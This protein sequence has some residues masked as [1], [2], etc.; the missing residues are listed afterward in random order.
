MR[1]LTK[2]IIENAVADYNIKQIY[3]KIANDE[4]IFPHIVF[5][6]DAY[7]QSSDDLNRFNYVVYID[8]YDKKTSKYSIEEIADRI[9]DDEQDSHIRTQGSRCLFKNISQIGRVSNS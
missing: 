9:V 5:D 2:S 1:K 3:Y 7:S 8:I 6:I 4:A